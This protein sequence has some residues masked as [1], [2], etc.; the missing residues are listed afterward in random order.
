MSINNTRKIRSLKRNLGDND[1]RVRI[2]A[3][4]ALCKIGEPAVGELITL[5]GDTD[6]RV[7]DEAKQSLI[8]LGESAA[9]ELISRYRRESTAVSEQSGSILIRIG[10]GAVHPLIGAV[11]DAT[12]GYAVMIFK[13]FDRKLYPRLQQKIRER[14]D[15]IDKLTYLLVEIGEPAIEPLHSV[16]DDA[17]YFAEPLGKI[18]KIN[19]AYSKTIIAALIREYLKAREMVPFVT[20]TIKKERPITIGT[21]SGVALTVSRWHTIRKLISAIAM[22][23]ETGDNQAIEC[24][25]RVLALFKEDNLAE[26]LRLSLEMG[27]SQ[28]SGKAFLVV[29]HQQHRIFINGSEAI[30]HILEGSVTSLAQET[31]ELVR[32]ALDYHP[33]NEDTKDFDLCASQV[34]SRLADMGG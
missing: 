26:A 14:E 11:K 31:I 18:A 22:T 6:S 20:N 1:L 12:A 28:P 25:A 15:H 17:P 21:W 30:D 5:L 3:V 10:S 7:H 19:P 13:V 8:K 33:F 24:I 34:L 9:R 23:S 29:P 32:F 27:D 4:Q 2:D 16:L